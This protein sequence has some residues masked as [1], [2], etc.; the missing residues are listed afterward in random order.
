MIQATEQG[1]EMIVRNMRENHYFVGVSAK[2]YKRAKY[3]EEVFKNPDGSLRFKIRTGDLMKSMKSG[4]AEVARDGAITT[5]VRA[6]GKLGVGMKYAKDVE[7]GTAKTRPFPFMRPAMEQE[8][9]PILKRTIKLLKA[10]LSRL[11]GR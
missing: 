2:S 4:D 11:R 10:K 9:G 5:K 7:F 1:G 3:G 6:S 8:K